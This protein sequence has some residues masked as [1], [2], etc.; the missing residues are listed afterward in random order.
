[1]PELDDQKVER[2]PQSKYIELLVADLVRKKIRE[3]L[4]EYGWIV[5]A[6]ALVLAIGAGFTLKGISED[7]A[8]LRDAEEE[9]R[10]QLTTTEEELSR[11]ADELRAKLEADFESVRLGFDNQLQVELESIESQ[12]DALDNYIQLVERSNDRALDR[13]DRQTESLSQ[14]GR[15][16]LV[17]AL[18]ARS[19]REDLESGLNDALNEAESTGRALEAELETVRGLRDEIEAKLAVE[20]LFIERGKKEYSARSDP[21]DVDAY[22]PGWI[23]LE[24]GRTLAVTFHRFQQEEQRVQLAPSPPLSSVRINSKIAVVDLRLDGSLLRENLRLRQG[25]GT[26][27]S[28]IGYRIEP[29]FVYLPNPEGTGYI[30]DFIW[31]RFTRLGSR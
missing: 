28:E 6:L 1:M 23:E 12:G 31:L 25:D 16:A 2:P 30:P 22:R 11:K 4:R 17:T 24:D 14:A 27:I 7:L 5:A 10:K 13:I 18:E 29:L 8:S 15:E 20:Y 26:T 9:L 19:L 21:S 3:S